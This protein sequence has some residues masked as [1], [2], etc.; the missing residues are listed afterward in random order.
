MLREK[1]LPRN[2]TLTR[3][4]DKGSCGSML[5]LVQFGIF[6]CT[7]VLLH[8]CNTKE[9]TKLYKERN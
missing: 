3:V 9:N 7:G 5:P 1:L 6:L 4:G 8:E 2:N